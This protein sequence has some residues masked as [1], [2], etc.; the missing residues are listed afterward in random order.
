M[1]ASFHSFQQM[2]V[3]HVAIRGEDFGQILEIGW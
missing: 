2:T 3:G 1:H